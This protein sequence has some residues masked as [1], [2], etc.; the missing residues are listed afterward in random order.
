MDL[1]LRTLSKPDSFMALISFR[2]C[3]IK[4]TVYLIN[5]WKFHFVLSLLINLTYSV[6]FGIAN[7]HKNFFLHLK[8]IWIPRETKLWKCRKDNEIF[9]RMPRKQQIKFWGQ[10]KK[11]TDKNYQ[12]KIEMMSPRKRPK[13]IQ[14][15]RKK[16]WIFRKLVNEVQNV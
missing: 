9:V 10:A 3:E 1:L 5:I 8:K 4:S 2:S 16:N 6:H 11:I 7:F 13:K 14:S 12:K 15:V